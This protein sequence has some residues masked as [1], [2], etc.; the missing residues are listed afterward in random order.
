KNLADSLEQWESSLRARESELH[1]DFESAISSIRQRCTEIISA[2]NADV[3]KATSEFK[4][5]TDKT[6]E[7]LTVQND[8][9]AARVE[10]LVSLREQIKKA[11]SEIESVKGSLN[12]ILKELKDSQDEQDASLEDL[13]QKVS[14]AKSNKSAKNTP[15]QPLPKSDSEK[16]SAANNQKTEPKTNSKKKQPDK[17][18]QQIRCFF[19]QNFKEEKY[20]QKKEQIIQAVLSSK[21]KQQ[22]NCALQ[23]TFPSEETSVIYKRLLPLFKSLP[24]Q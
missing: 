23:K 19:G 13:K 18:E 6:L 12:E 20:K 14:E 7:R 24:G 8:K 11:T 2:F 3:S 10:E 21:T 17:R 15:T 9:L 5:E 22:V 4:T 1:G 16:K